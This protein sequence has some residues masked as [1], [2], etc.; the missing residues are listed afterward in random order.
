MRSNLTENSDHRALRKW[1]SAGMLFPE[2]VKLHGDAG[3][4]LNNLI[5]KYSLAADT[6]AISFAALAAFTAR[7]WTSPRPTAAA[8]SATRCFA[9]KGRS[10]D[11]PDIFCRGQENRFDRKVNYTLHVVK[12]VAFGARS[13]LDPKPDCTQHFALIDQS[14]RFYQQWGGHLPWIHTADH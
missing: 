12:Q 9:S 11:S 5:A 6:Y 13:A 3:Y 2:V 10:V 7:A 4:L 1:L 14:T 8:P